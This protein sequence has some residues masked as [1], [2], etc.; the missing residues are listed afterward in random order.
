[1]G[2]PLALSLNSVRALNWT[3]HHVIPGTQTTQITSLTNS[4]V[5]L[6]SARLSTPF[7]AC[8][9]RISSFRWQEWGL[10]T[11]SLRAVIKLRCMRKTLHTIS[12]ELAPVLHQATKEFRLADVRRHYGSWSATESEIAA[13]REEILRKLESLPQPARDVERDVLRRLNR[14]DERSRTL[15]RTTLKEMWEEGTLCYLNS[16]ERF[17]R[18]Q[19]RYGILRH[20]FPHLDLNSV[21]IDTAKERL[22]HAHVCSYG[23]VTVKDSA[24]WSGLSPRRVSLILSSLREFIV[25][26]QVEGFREEFF[27]SKENLEGIGESIVVAEP[28]AE[29]LAHEDPSLKG[30]YESRRR[31]VSDRFTMKLFNPIGEARA[32]IVCSG[33]VVGTWE[34]NQRQRCVRLKRFRE[35]NKDEN[36]LISASLVKL[37]I[38][39]ESNESSGQWKAEGWT[40]H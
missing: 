31:Y 13:I 37:L 34:L 4:L 39:L 9:P 14:D 38:F 12:C 10:T 17:G 35:T 22:V 6:H 18:E 8:R 1:M 2:N 20:E 27:I 23:P 28:W 26:V 3:Q 29:F 36:K 25:P 5:G 21:D 24:W 32:S 33:E 19:R 40:P 15:I 7:F 16:S 11:Q 30:Y